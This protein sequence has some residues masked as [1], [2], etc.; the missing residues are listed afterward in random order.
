MRGLKY[1]V[2]YLLVGIGIFAEQGYI[3]SFNTLRLGENQ[4]DYKLISKIIKGLDIVGLIEIIDVNGV[5]N[6]LDS[7]EKESE[8]K[9]DYHISPYPVGHTS[10]KEYFGFIWKRDRVKFLGAQGFYS[11]NDSEFS[12]PPYGAD[13]K[14]DEFDFTF[15][16]VHS[17]FG[18]NK[19]QRKFEAKRIHKVYDYFQKKNGS[20]NDVVIAGDFNLS[21]LDEAFDKFLK[22]KDM[23]IYTINPFIK[24]TLGKDRLVSSYDNMFL[25]KIY[26]SE[27]KGESGAIDFTKNAYIEMKKK[28]SD[29]LPIFIV[30]DTDFDD[31]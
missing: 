30:V 29:H 5:E 14:I 9:W 7:L 31:D 10:Y 16:L 1:L 2:I 11:D 28:V 15:I 3:S 6:L 27:F 19:E 17:I 13:F 4:K 25:S 20:E 12:R 24:T 21:A 26:T 22:H 23:I 18:K 8:E